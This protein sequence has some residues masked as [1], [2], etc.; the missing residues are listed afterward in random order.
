[1]KYIAGF[2]ILTIILPVLFNC[3]AENSDDKFSVLGGNDLIF[4]VNRISQH[5]NVQFPS[6][7]LNEND[8]L[9]TDDGPEYEISFS[10]NMQTVSFMNDSISGTI[11]EDTEEYQKYDL[12]NG[13]FAGGRFVVWITEDQFEA[14]LTI[15]G[16][17]VP[18]I[19]SE[20]GNI[21]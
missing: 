13:L 9:K 21:R 15:Y 11:M 8:Y 12:N 6:D 10:E 5:P 7:Q 14:E 1:M 3:S 16:S 19:R 18:I 20:R 17:G 4:E 2:F